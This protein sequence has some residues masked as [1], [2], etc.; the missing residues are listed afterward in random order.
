MKRYRHVTDM[1]PDKISLQNMEKNQSESFKQYAQ[2][3]REVV[4]QVQP[5]LLEKETT[6]LF[7][8]TL[9]APFIN[10]MLENATMSFS[11]IVISGEMIEKAVR[12]GKIDVRESTKRLTSKKN[13]NEVDNVSV[14]SKGYHKPI[15][16]DQ[17]RVITTSH[18]GPSRQESNSEPNL[19]K[20]QFTPI[21]MTYRELYQNLFNAHVVSPF[22]LEPVQPPCPKWY[23]T[24]AQC[25]YHAGITKH[26][27]ENCTTFKKLIERLIRMDIMKF[28]NPFGVENPLPNHADNGANTIIENAGKRIKKNIA[29]VKTPLK[30]VLKQ[31]IDRGLIIQDLKE[32][33]KGMRGYCEFHAEEGHEI[34]ECR[35]QSFYTNPNR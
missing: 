26:S 6:M 13:E 28:D 24:N 32:M 31:M 18:Q 25:E 16:M 11:D 17:S 33:P 3:W 14:F 4:T 29:E 35:I 10:H 15:T 2:R 12:S 20:L 19:E 1:T 27:I 21:P 34:H 8:N 23:D 7:I 22:Y 30:W 5:P 9:K